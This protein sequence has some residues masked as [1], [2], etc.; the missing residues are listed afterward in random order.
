MKRFTFLM[1]GMMAAL[2]HIQ[3]TAAAEGWPVN[4]GGVMLQGF[5]WDSYNDTK[6]TNLESQA[7]TLAEYFDLIWVPQ[8]GYCN[9]LSNQMGYSDIWWFDQKSCFGTADELKSMI[10]TFKSKGLLTIADVVINHKN[11]NTSWC[12]FPTETWNNQTMTWSLADICQTDECNNSGNLPKWS[13][14]GQK[15]TG[16]KDTGSNF[17]GCR[18]L[19]HTSANVQKNI[20]LYLQFLQ[21][22]MGYA[23]FR[24]DMTGGYA[25]AYT[26]IYNEAA[27][28]AYSVGEYW[29][30]DGLSGLQKWIDGT[31][32]T[33]AAFDFQL[34]GLI[35]NSFNNNS[36][37]QL[38]NYTSQSLIGSGY[39]RYAVTFADNHDT[40]RSD[41]NNGANMLRSNIEAAN[42]YILTMPGTP[43]V[44]LTHWMGYK[45]AIKKQIR[46]RK[47]AGV[48][49]QSKVVESKGEANGYSVS[50]QGENGKMLLCLG[51][52][53]TSTSGYQL[54][55]QGTNYKLY[56][57]D[58]IDATD[59]QEDEKTEEETTYPDC[60]KYIEGKF[61][62]YFEKPATG[63]NSV[64]V[65]V[66]NK[67]STGEEYLGKS[68]PGVAAT[69][70]GT[71][72]NGNEIWLWTTDNSAAPDFIIFNNNAG[73]QTANLDFINGGYYNVTGG[74][75][76]VTGIENT[77]RQ[78]TI[79]DD[80]YFSIS[81][82]Q[83]LPGR[84]GVY[85]HKGKKI[86]K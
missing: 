6:W 32:K 4:Y 69:K 81:G 1:T 5:Y 79:K 11:G 64:N 58:D 44:W 27:N 13:N 72:D 74:H 73:Q 29:M 71:A 9:S 16:A 70:V 15:A 39:D 85:I 43:C 30:N 76:V 51:I 52:T 61:F 38:A 59:I 55:A 33:S 75:S 7:E 82:Q 21:E 35:N 10:Q 8:S 56:I 2:C 3:T 24:Y 36:W 60:V 62:A 86:I 48:T 65:W 31:G 50:V 80:R 49:N 42:A 28:P 54:V 37:S 12:D 34:K 68:W 26:K 41:Q 77:K 17:D 18:D 83:A 47:L 19:D 20:K 53:T 46:A 22:E 40:G 14:N 78:E 23:G 57:S 67:N 25:P 63:W 66:W 84:H 45:E